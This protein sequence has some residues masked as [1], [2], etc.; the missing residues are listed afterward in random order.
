MSEAKKMNKKFLQIGVTAALLL[1]VM[2][3]TP[4]LAK[5]IRDD[6][7]QMVQQPALGTHAPLYVIDIHIYLGKAFNRTFWLNITLRPSTVGN[8]TN[9]Q[10]DGIS[11]TLLGRAIGD[12][13]VNTTIPSMKPGQ[14]VLIKVPAERGLAIMEYSVNAHYQ[15]NGTTE[16]VQYGPDKYLLFLGFVRDMKG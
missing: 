10:V 13:T 12:N 11:T 16:Q 3:P 4:I 7:D 6:K 2:L 14:S 5:Q 8:A 15:Y 1:V 9:I